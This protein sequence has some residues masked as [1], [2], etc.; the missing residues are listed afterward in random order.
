MS[1]PSFPSMRAVPP[2]PTPILPDAP[3]PRCTDAGSGKASGRR[4]LLWV[5]AAISMAML[6]G[7]G[8]GSGG[9]DP[10]SPAPSP[11]T[12]APNPPAPNP[13][14]PNPPA[15]NP[16]APAPSDGTSSAACFNQAD[17][18]EGTRLEMEQDVI[19]NGQTEKM[20][21]VI[22]TRGREAF[23]GAN[24]VRKLRTQYFLN[25]EVSDRLYTDFVDGNIVHYGTRNG[26]EGTDPAMGYTYNDPLIRK[27]VMS[28]GQKID[29]NY[30][31]RSVEGADGQV[32]GAQVVTGTETYDGRVN[33]DTPMGVIASC[34]FTGVVKFRQVDGSDL[35]QIQESWVAADGAYRGQLLKLATRTDDQVGTI[36]VTKISYAPK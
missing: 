17:L 26:G 27:P 10:S 35:T 8:G 32:R 1:L 19:S 2:A 6:A 9:S 7:C 36:V 34:K 31:V 13:P 18:H 16:P 33:L 24:P 4:S 30:T 12:P 23:M 29:M 20:R 25:T 28:P 14:A 11:S 22:L 15:P 3:A 21:T 5:S